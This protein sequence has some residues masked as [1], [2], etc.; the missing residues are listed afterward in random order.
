MKAK[1]MFERLGYKWNEI[2]NDREDLIIYYNERRLVFY[3]RRRL[4]GKD[5]LETGLTPGEIQA[6]HQQCKELGWFD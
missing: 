6:I 4:V 1:E 5:G 3:K 2:T